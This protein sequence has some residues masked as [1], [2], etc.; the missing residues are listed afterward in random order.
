MPTDSDRYILAIDL[1]TSGP[2]VAL[3]SVRGEIVAWD[4]EATALI[5]LPNGG[6]E[7]SPDDWWNAIKK[8]TARLL[9]KRLIPIEHI[10]AV[11]CT[12]QWSGTVAVDRAGRHLMNAVIW[13]DARG[14]P[15]AQRVTDGLIKIEGYGLWKLLKWIRLAGG[16]PG[17]TGKDSIAHILYIKHDLPAICQQ[18]Y[19]FLEPKDYLNLRLTGR[20]AASFDSIALHWVTDNRNIPNVMYD[21]GLLRMSTL[22]RDKLPDLKRATDILGTIKPEVADELG[23]P[24]T[25][26]VV[27]GT[28]DVQSAA[29]GSGAVR[30]YEAHLYIGTS[31]WLACH[32]PFKKT[33]VFHNIASLPSA[34]PGRYIVSN[35]QQT[36][37]A[38]LAFLKRNVLSHNNGPSTG[39]GAPDVYEFLDQI[40]DRTPAGSGKVIFTPWL[41]GERTPVGDHLVRSGMYNLSLQTT[42]DQ[43]IRA[44]FEGVAYN[45][46]WLL[47]YVEKFVGRRFSGVNMV[48]GG[49]K[50]NVWCQ[51]HADVFDRP[52]RQVKDPILVN[53]RGAAFLASVALGYLAFDE[54]SECVPIAQTYEPNPQ[55]RK[56]YDELFQEFVN[57]YKS[58]KSIYTRL[59]RMA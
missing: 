4:F 11:S 53:V 5:L 42:R 45:A 55:N 15:Y 41:Q 32:V 3:A 46:K 27:T 23:L 13:L 31:A 22:D 54:V 25:A 43:I 18:T 7:Q 2:K 19:K 39:A 29:I 58:N 34:I 38:C 24:R 10:V 59:N 51:I 20:F 21:E 57:L 28:P 40:A 16:A 48:G 52:I 47:G 50:S 35:E 8:A 33:D 6:A 17:R 30:D 36:A 14:A 56:V 9:E 1:G 44:V 26:Q 49:A 37:G 12:A